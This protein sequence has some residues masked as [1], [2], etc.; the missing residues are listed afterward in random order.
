MTGATPITVTAGTTVSGIHFCVSDRTELPEVL[1]EPLQNVVSVSPLSTGVLRFARSGAENDYALPVKYRLSGSASPGTDYTITGWNYSDG[2]SVTI[3]EGS[4][5]AVCTIIPQPGATWTNS[6]V[7]RVTIV[8]NQ[9]GKTPYT[10]APAFSASVNIYTNGATSWTNWLNDYFSEAEQADP[11]FSGPDS[12]AN[13][14]GIPNLMEYYLGRN[15]RAD[16]HTPPFTMTPGTVPSSSAANMFLDAGTLLG[17]EGLAYANNQS[18]SRESGEPDHAGVRGYDSVWW[19]W[20]APANGHLTA[21]T[22]GSS[23]DTLL[24]IYT[25]SLVSALT[26][27]GSNDDDC[28]TQSRVT[29]PVKANITYHVAVDAK[30]MPGNIEFWWNFIPQIAMTIPQQLLQNLAGQFAILTY[31]RRIGV[32]EAI[33]YLEICPD[34]ISGDWCQDKNCVKILSVEPKG[35]GIREIVRSQIVYTGNCVAVRLTVRPT[36]E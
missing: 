30:Y 21:E 11:S 20:T 26:E 17:V 13:T 18:A 3:P 35:D 27:I 1:L 9:W 7:I 28:D 10:I 2:G 24:G 6:K 4:N 36:S 22:C 29:V 8:S 23:F 14:N 25:G 33:G 12:D 19:K 32:T 5:S 15:P 34:L 16:D 31:E